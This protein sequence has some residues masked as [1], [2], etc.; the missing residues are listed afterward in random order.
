MAEKIRLSRV[1]FCS[2]ST[3]YQLGHLQSCCQGTAV[4]CSVCLFTKGNA[5]AEALKLLDK[6]SQSG[7]VL[8][9]L[10]LLLPEKCLGFPSHLCHAGALIAL[11]LVSLLRCLYT[12]MH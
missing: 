1:K 3:W 9:S 5:S 11:F 12:F 7:G 6:K 4:D 2:C 10:F 8:S